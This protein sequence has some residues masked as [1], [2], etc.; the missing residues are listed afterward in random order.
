[1]IAINEVFPGLDDGQKQ[2]I[3]DRFDSWYANLKPPQ[4]AIA[5]E[6]IGKIKDYF[7]GRDLGNGTITYQLDKKITGPW[8]MIFGAQFQFN[9]NWMT[10]VEMGAFGKRSQFLFSTN[11]RFQSIRHKSK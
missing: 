6:I 11:Y 2:Q 10:R 3:K 1:V 8:N 5:G 4:Q 7:D 9:K